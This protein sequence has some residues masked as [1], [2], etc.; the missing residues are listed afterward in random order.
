M[1]QLNTLYKPGKK[2]N[3][4]TLRNEIVN[5]CRSHRALAHDMFIQS[6]NVFASRKTAYV[7]QTTRE[8]AFLNDR[9]INRRG[10][11]NC[12]RAST[13]SRL[14]PR[15]CEA[16]ISLQKKMGV[17]IIVLFVQPRQFYIKVLIIFLISSINLVPLIQFRRF[18]PKDMKC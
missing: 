6:G 5:S 14:S 1:G 8:F 10:T 15:W 13:A 18:E 11:R 12:D 3:Q 16:D 2:Q 4:A 9:I 7:S 17:L